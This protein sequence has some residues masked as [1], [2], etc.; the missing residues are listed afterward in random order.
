MTRRQCTHCPWRTDVDPYDIPNGYS[1]DK[2]CG[3]KNTIARPGDLSGLFGPMHLMACHE[4]KPGHEI[5]CVGWLA[6]QLGPGNNIALRLRV[7]TGV[8]DADV[9]TVGPQHARLEDTLPRAARRRR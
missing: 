9:E 1:V 6:N 7:A 2:H 8:V 5:V 3:L 4:S